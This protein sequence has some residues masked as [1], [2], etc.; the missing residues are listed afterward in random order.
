MLRHLRGLPSARLDPAERVCGSGEAASAGDAAGAVREPRWQASATPFFEVPGR[1]WSPLRLVTSR[2]TLPLRWIIPSRGAAMPIGNQVC[3]EMTSGLE[4]HLVHEAF[5]LPLHLAGDGSLNSVV[6]WANLFV[7]CRWH[8][9]DSCAGNGDY[10]GHHRW[11]K[12]MQLLG[13]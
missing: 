11:P 3:D 6:N 12:E 13:P 9:S 1:W 5:D 4:S 8:R 7:P 10:R 2:R